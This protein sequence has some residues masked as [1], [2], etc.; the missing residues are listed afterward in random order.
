[1]KNR[2]L[3]DVTPSLAAL[4]RGSVRLASG[5][6]EL[7]IADFTETLEFKVE[8]D[9]V[10]AYNFRG[11]A[12]RNKGDIDKAIEDFNA[13]IAGKSDYA[14][15]YNNR[16]LAYRR[17][18]EVDR[19]IED[20]NTALRLKPNFSHAYNNRGLAY[21]DKDDID[22]AISDFDEAIKHR[23]D[24]ARAYNNRGDAYREQGKVHR[25]IKDFSKAIELRPELV[26]AYDNR[27]DAYQ[28]KEDYN[29]AIDDYTTVIRREPTCPKAYLKRGHAF[30]LRGDV[31]AAIADFDTASQHNPEFADAYV[32]RA[33]AYW[34]ASKS[35]SAID[36]NI[37][38]EL[39]TIK[40]DS[41]K[42]VRHLA[43][44]T[45][46]LRVQIVAVLG[47]ED[48][49]PYSDEPSQLYGVFKVFQELVLANI[50]PE[51]F[52]DMLAQTLCYGL[53]AARC[54]LPDGAQF[55]RDTAAEVL[56]TFNPFLQ[57]LFAL[58]FGERITK[59]LDYIARFL[60]KVSPEMLRTTLEAQVHGGGP[61]TQFYET[62]LTAYDTNL[63]V[64]NTP[65]PVISYIVRS[66]DALLKTNQEKTDGLASGSTLILNPATSGGFFSASIAQ[67]RRRVPKT[68]GAAAWGSYV[69]SQLVQRLIGFE[70]SVARYTMAHLNLSL[71]LHKQGWAPG[72]DERI[73][74]YLTN[75]LDELVER[76]GY[77]F[78]AF[79]SDEANAA[80][81]VKR[82]EPISAII[83]NLVYPSSPT[84]PNRTWRG[85]LTF[86][87]ELMED[88]KSVDGKPLP[89]INQS[90]L[91]EDAA[92]FIRWA[93]WRIGKTGEGV[94]GCVV[95]NNFLDSKV[96]AGMRQS[97]LNSFNAIYHLNL[98]GREK[99]NSPSGVIDE[100]LFDIRPGVSILLCVKQRQNLN[101]ARIYY[102]DVWGTRAEKY[103]V[104][105]ETDVLNTEW[106]ELYPTSPLYLFVPQH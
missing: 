56:S 106:Q 33:H 43:Q 35:D 95:N 59:G 4:L 49:Q 3:N 101:P 102:A 77:G 44:H 66:T 15:A 84:T 55:S 63:G 11:I 48:S 86:I 9:C 13:A 29:F 88:Y 71:L 105:S 91:H 25:A 32:K 47:D 41:A 81:S 78:T 18:S 97:L 67:L 52:A 21:R 2:F 98:H 1:M 54:W 31:E 7:A 53:C 50:T 76:K 99:E 36:A 38:A 74:I 70:L 94:I 10:R 45:R 92:K 42:L 20:F 46:E 6:Y 27:G 37:E 39:K 30:Q 82:D 75:T 104:L 65:Q 60:A 80:V 87:G 28:D 5:E 51:D 26:E 58:D 24:F 12:Y 19:A 85:E 79:M 90:R 17:K 89:G 62:F 103:R 16:G 57:S 100:N 40:S 96:F 93:Q 64:Y 22:R 83:G 23:A 14:E 34:L 61:C 72:G 8:P 68:A 73:R 69:N